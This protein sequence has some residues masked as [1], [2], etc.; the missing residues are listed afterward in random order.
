MGGGS[1]STETQTTDVPEW[2]KP[3][4]ERTLARAETE[5]LKPYEA[6]SGQRQALSSQYGDIGAAQDLT[7]NIAGSGVAGL[8]AAQNYSNYAM[9]QSKALGQY[10]PTQ[11]TTS[12]FSPYAGYQASSA[13]PYAGY[14]ATSATPYSGFQAGSADPYSNF[15]ASSATPYS[16]FTA[17]EYSQAQFNPYSSFQAG[18]ADPYSQFQESQFNEYN[19]D[20]SRQFSG[21]EVQ[22]YM[23]PYMQNVVDQQSKSAVTNFN[24]QNAARAAQGVSAGA[25]GGSRQGVVQGMAEEGL[26]G[27]LDQIQSKGLQDSYT[28]AM[29]AFQS[30]RAAQVSNEQARA[31]EAA[32]VQSAG[33]SEAARVQSAQAGELA[34]TQ[35]IGL[36]EASR[37]QAAQAAEAARTQSG[38]AGELG[39]V[40]SAV[41]SDQARIQAAQAAELARTQGIDVN[42]A[43]RIQQAQ[44]AELARTQG[45]SLDEASRIQAAQAGEQ[46]RVQ[47]IDVAEQSRIQQ[48]QAAE[49]ARTQGVDQSEAARIQSGLAGEQSRVQAANA[50]EAARVQAQNEASNQFGAGQGLS[51]LGAGASAAQALAGYGQLGREADIQNAQLL[52]TIGQANQLEGQ[53]GMDIAYQD[54]LTKQGYTQQQIA[55]MGNMVNG[56]PVANAGTSTTVGTPATPGFGQQVLGAGLTGLS[57][58]KAFKDGG[59]VR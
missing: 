26:A 18:S 19:Y 4:F 2:A 1:P 52:Q 48:A 33:G 51:A 10:T 40:Q 58:Y 41:G 32:R 8:A 53:Q 14:Q 56:L 47:G 44:A 46:G 36:D 37:V 22:N 34:R 24:R 29:S 12:S 30:D 38:I 21:Q 55:N 20:P 50:A 5:S 3:Y 23:N 17:G 11:T 31:A 9:D 35:G 42:E 16:D 54:F 43:S 7:R 27:Q 45:I 28:Q 59:L 13:D 6:Y 25:F 49:L 57:L 39:R 15:K